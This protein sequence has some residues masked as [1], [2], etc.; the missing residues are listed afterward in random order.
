VKRIAGYGERKAIVDAED[1]QGPSFET[2]MKAAVVSRAFPLETFRRRKD[3]TFKHHA[4][5][6]AL[7][8]DEA[9]TLLDW[10]KETPK[11]RCAS[12]GFQGQTRLT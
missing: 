4:E 12:Y 5:V 1:C 6:A 8:P 10:C 7:Q 9:D 2:C 3:L 11:P